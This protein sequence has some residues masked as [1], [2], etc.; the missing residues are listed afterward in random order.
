ML[1]SSHPNH[2]SSIYNYHDCLRERY[3]LKWFHFLHSNDSN[4]FQFQYKYLV[5]TGINYRFDNRYNL[6]YNNRHFLPTTVIGIFLSRVEYAY[7]H[8]KKYAYYRYGIRHI[9]AYYRFL[10][11]VQTARSSTRYLSFFFLRSSHAFF[12][13][14]RADFSDRIKVVSY[15]SSFATVVVHLSPCPRQLESNRLDSTQ[16]F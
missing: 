3:W 9:Y 6:P 1:N 13:S 11:L 5:I 2:S 8:T 7:Y 15:A 4:Q 10:W 14:S 12:F 16:L